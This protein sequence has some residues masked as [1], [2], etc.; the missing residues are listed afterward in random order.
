LPLLRHRGQ[1]DGSNSAVGYNNVNGNYAALASAV[2]AANAAKLAA[3]NN[4]EIAKQLAEVQA[5]ETL[6]GMGGFGP[7]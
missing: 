7:V 5:R 6:R 4:A 2:A 3:V 1:I